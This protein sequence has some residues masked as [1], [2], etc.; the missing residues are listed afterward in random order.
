LASFVEDELE[1]HAFGVVLSADE[2]VV[3][4]HFYVAGV[5]ALGTRRHAGIL[6][7][8]C[9]L[10]D[11]G[12]WKYRVDYFAVF[13]LGQSQTAKA[14]TIAAITR[15]PKNPSQRKRPCALYFPACI[16]G[17]GK[18]TLAPQSKQ[19]TSLTSNCMNAKTTALSVIAIAPLRMILLSGTAVILARFRLLTSKPK[20]ARPMEMP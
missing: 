6:I 5:V 16:Y 7:Y 18:P 15:S 12:G 2:A 3:F 9:G 1:A 14:G 17:N 4:L 19:W 20:T 11:A 8:A 10:C 13:P